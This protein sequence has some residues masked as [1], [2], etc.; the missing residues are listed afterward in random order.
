MNLVF[1][2][3]TKSVFTRILDGIDPEIVDTVKH[4]V[5]HIHEVKDITE[6]RVRWIG[7]HLHAELNIAID[8]RLTI[9]EG[10]L[11]AKEVRHQLLHHLKFLSNATI[12]VDPINASGEKFHEIVKHS[13]DD[14][15]PHCQS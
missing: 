2:E 10:H 3:T 5:E 9:K 7:H 1:M 15:P 12:H 6:I 8:P 11:I 4:T 13:H 14:L